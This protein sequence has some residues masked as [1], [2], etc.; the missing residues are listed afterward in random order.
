MGTH[1]GDEQASSMSDESL[2]MRIYRE[3]E[4]ARKAFVGVGVLREIASRFQCFVNFKPLS[5]KAKTRILAKQIIEMGFE[6]SHAI[7]Y[8]SPGIMQG[9]IDAAMSGDSLTV[10][11]FKSVIEGYLAPVFERAEVVENRTYRL[12]GS[13]EEPQMI[14][15]NHAR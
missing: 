6:Y 9:L 13:L 3:N 15:E 7:S 10:R 14:A 11:S 4:A 8:V 5:A 1:C 12:E 2:P